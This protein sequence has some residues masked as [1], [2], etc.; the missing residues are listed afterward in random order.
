M[1]TT[2]KKGGTNIVRHVSCGMDMLVYNISGWGITVIQSTTLVSLPLA[3]P[4]DELEV[5]LT[6]IYHTG[7]ECATSQSETV[8]SGTAFEL[9]GCYIPP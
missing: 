3:F 1:N 9:C 2:A 8:Q 6:A 7:K 5:S 4:R